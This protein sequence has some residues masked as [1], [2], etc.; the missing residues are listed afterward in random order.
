MWVCHSIFFLAGTARIVALILQIFY[1]LLLHY[2][3]FLTFAQSF[4]TT[5]RS[6]QLEHRRPCF[7]G[8]FWGF[9]EWSYISS[10]PNLIC[11]F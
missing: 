11:R 6:A 1:F 3:E 7:G 9:I 5:E 10:T 4:L 2:L 8:T